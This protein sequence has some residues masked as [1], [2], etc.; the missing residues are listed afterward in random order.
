MLR[1]LRQK[2]KNGQIPVASDA[3]APPSA[4]ELIGQELQLATFPD[5]YFRIM[6]VLNNPRS[7]AAQAADVV[8]K[9]VGLSAKLLKLVNSPLYGFPSKID[10]IQRAVTLVGSNELSMLALGVS[11]VQYFNDVPSDFMNME[12]FWKHSI[13][14][15]IFARIIAGQAFGLSEERFFIGGLIH[16]IGRLILIKNSPQS[17]MSVFHVA[18]SEDCVTLDAERRLLGYDHADLARLVLEQ[19]KFPDSLGQMI[20]NHH[21]PRNASNA[22]DAGIIHIADLLAKALEPQDREFLYLPPL[23]TETWKTLG[24][25]PSMIGPAM[26]QAG[27]LLSDIY[28]SFLGPES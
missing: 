25:A 13:A 23:D 1:F 2:D 7:S 21:T 17:A 8:S 4:K 12:S 18:R 10:T 22:Q 14:C 15:G 24:L 9:D 16:D 6:E 11:V 26:N 5:I 19:W 3:L 27:H 28:H 20:G